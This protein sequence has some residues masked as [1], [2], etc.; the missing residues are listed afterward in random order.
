MRQLATTALAILAVST[1]ASAIPI[2]NYQTSYEYP[3]TNTTLYRVFAEGHSP[4]EGDQCGASYRIRIFSHGYL[5]RSKVGSFNA[6]AFLSDSDA[7]DWTYGYAQTAFTLRGFPPVDFY[8]VCVRIAQVVRGDRY[9][10]HQVCK[11]E[12]IINPNV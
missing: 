2:Y 10:S 8:K 1:P 11:R 9:S 6:C 3:S 5:V 7:N 4:P 12:Q